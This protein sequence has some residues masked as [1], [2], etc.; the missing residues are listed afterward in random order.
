MDL[1]QTNVSASRNSVL[2]Q[3]PHTKKVKLPDVQLQLYAMDYM[4]QMKKETGVVQ[5]ASIEFR[6]SRLC[7][8]S[9]EVPHTFVVVPRSRRKASVKRFL[10]NRN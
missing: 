3:L 8:D 2:I 4:E 9:E 7:H 1:T 10:L 5:A 6:S